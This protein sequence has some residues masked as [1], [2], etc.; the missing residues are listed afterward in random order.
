MKKWISFILTSIVLQTLPASAFVIESG[1][2]QQDS[3][4]YVKATKITC[5]SSTAQDCNSLCQNESICQRVEPYCRNC[6]GTASS[7]LR[8]LF[9]QISKLYAIKSELSD[10]SV[11][12]Q[13]LAS[14]SYVLL[15]MKSTYNY[16]TPVGGDAFLQEMQV[17]CGKKADTALLVVRL[18][19]AHQPAELS[20]ILCRNDS[21][22]TTAFE[23]QPRQPEFGQ[24]PLSTPLIFKLN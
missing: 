18:D 2:I 6:G 11:L 1:Y 15:D 20:Y 13:Y 14:A 22:Q 12:V 10:R 5:D 9:T 23:V 3:G 17:F 4:Q 16:Y 19:E 21:G 8:Q 7:L 24:Q